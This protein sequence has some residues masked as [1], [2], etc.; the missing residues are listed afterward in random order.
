MNSECWLH[1]GSI[2][3]DGYGIVFYDGKQLRAHRV[4]YESEVGLIPDGLHIDHLCR[5]RVCINPGHMEVVENVTNIMRGEAPSAQ[6]ARKTHCSKGHPFDEVNTMYRK[7]GW[8]ICIE[9]KKEWWQS[10]KPRRKYK[11]KV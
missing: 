2:N 10:Y 4:M 11:I 7:N 8:R 1:A 6:N 3:S 5:T 9:C